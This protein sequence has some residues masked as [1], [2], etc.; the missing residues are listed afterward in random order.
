M[1]IN[2]KMKALMFGDPIATVNE[3]CGKLRAR[4]I[5]PLAFEANLVV[6]QNWTGATV[7]G[8]LLARTAAVTLDSNTIT[9]PAP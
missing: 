4:K 6:F 1:Q 2:R 7:E 5:L 9:I 8:R 3:A